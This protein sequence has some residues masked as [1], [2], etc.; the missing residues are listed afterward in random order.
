MTFA[1]KA[2]LCNLHDLFIQAT[3]VLNRVKKWSE[4]C[5][6]INKGEKRRG[7]RRLRNNGVTNEAYFKLR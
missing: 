2:D 4:L 7:Q 1:K 3:Y 5:N 6:T